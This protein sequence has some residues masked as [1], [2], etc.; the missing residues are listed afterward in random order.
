MSRFD[1]REWLGSILHSV[2][3]L[4]FADM[5]EEL[6]QMMAGAAAVTFCVFV[7]V[8]MALGVPKWLAIGGAL[9]VPVV[10]FAVVGL[11]RRRPARS[12]L[13]LSQHRSSIDAR[14]P[15]VKGGE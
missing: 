14:R 6:F 5:E 3:Q 15:S 13:G 7:S 9:A 12:T 4:F 10:A 8:G 11:T 2:H 1:P